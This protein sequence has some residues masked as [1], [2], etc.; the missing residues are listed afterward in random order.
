MGKLTGKKPQKGISN[1]IKKG[2]GKLGKGQLLHITTFVGMKTFCFGV[3]LVYESMEYILRQLPKKNF[4]VLFITLSIF[5]DVTA[6]LN[7]Q[8]LSLHNYMYMYSTCD[9]RE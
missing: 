8:L 2:G 5:A 1:S 4:S 6:E 3:Y 7:K 9:K